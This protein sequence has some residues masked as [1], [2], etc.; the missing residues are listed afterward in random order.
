MR[1]QLNYQTLDANSS[2]VRSWGLYLVLGSHVQ[3]YFFSQINVNRAGSGNG[4]G[5]TNGK[6]KWIFDW[7]HN[8]MW[9]AF[10]SSKTDNN[11]KGRKKRKKHTN[12]PEVEFSP[13]VALPPSYLNVFDRISYIYFIFVS[14]LQLSEIVAIEMKLA[15]RYYCKLSDAAERCF[16]RPPPF[17]FQPPTLHPPPLEPF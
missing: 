16:A 3:A 5:N 7:V 4:N 6:R 15:V 12:S 1:L 11:D 8:K 13:G 2:W 10:Y 14:F 17:P 9:N